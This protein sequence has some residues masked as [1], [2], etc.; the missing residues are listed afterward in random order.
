MTRDARALET[1]KTTLFHLSLEYLK[2]SPYCVGHA[3]AVN[4]KTKNT[5]ET[6]ELVTLHLY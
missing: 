4:I 3:G 1:K 2:E 5:K 6:T